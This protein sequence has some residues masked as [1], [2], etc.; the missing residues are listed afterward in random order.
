MHGKKKPFHAKNGSKALC[1]CFVVSVRFFNKVLKHVHGY[2]WMKKWINY[3]YLSLHIDLGR[4]AIPNYTRLVLKEVPW[5]IS[6]ALRCSC[7][8]FWKRGRSE[9]YNPTRGLQIKVLN[10]HL[11]LLI[12]LCGGT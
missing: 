11:F 3:L 12:C 6:P 8:F 7:P 5:L 1:A 9:K 10:L 4:G 2:I